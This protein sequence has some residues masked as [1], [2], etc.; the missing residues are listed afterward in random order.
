MTTRGKNWSDKKLAKF[1][2]KGFE[3]HISQYKEKVKLKMYRLQI[4][5]TLLEEKE[6]DAILGV[7]PATKPSLEI[8]S[9]TGLPCD[10]F[11]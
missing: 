7:K 9:E 8:S 10:L 11:R 2:E 4:T 5:I 3:R 6:L 1:Y